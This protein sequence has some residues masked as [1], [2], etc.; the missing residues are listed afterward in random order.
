ME[1]ISIAAHRLL[2]GKLHTIGKAVS[3]KIAL[4]V[5]HFPCDFYISSVVG[6]DQLQMGQCIVDH[7][8]LIFTSHRANSI[9]LMLDLGSVIPF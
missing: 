7:V 9:L 1:H 3:H 8:L 6:R 5:S 2:I 4:H